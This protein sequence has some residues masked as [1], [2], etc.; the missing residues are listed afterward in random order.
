M[1][2]LLPG[3]EKGEDLCRQRCASLFLPQQNPLK[4]GKENL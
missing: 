3:K 4:N 2:F 1:G